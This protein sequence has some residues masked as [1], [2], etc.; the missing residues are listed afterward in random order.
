VVEEVSK[1]DVGGDGVIDLREAIR[2]LKIVVGVE[3]STD[4]P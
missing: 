1:W 3:V 2:A 4:S